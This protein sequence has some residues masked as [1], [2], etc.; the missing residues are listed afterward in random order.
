MT[1]E[2]REIDPW[3]SFSYDFT[4]STFRDNPFDLWRR[5]RKECPVAHG[6]E[7]ARGERFLVTSRYEDT[8]FAAQSP[9]LFTTTQGVTLPP[10]P[11]P[12]LPLELDGASHREMRKIMNPSLAPQRV[13]G[14]ES[15]LRA[16]ARITLDAL[17]G[18]TELDICGDFSDPYVKNSMLT[19]LGFPRV[20][21]P[22]LRYWTQLLSDHPSFHTADELAQI[23]GQCVPYLAQS[24]RAAR[25]RDAADDTLSIVAHGTIEGRELQ[26]GEQVSMMLLLILGALTTTSATLAG[27]LYWLADH[28]E[29]RVRLR[30]QPELLLTAVDEFVRYTTPVAHEAR[31]ATSTTVLGGCP[32]PAGTKVVL[33]YGSANRDAEVFDE[34]EDIVLDRHPNRHLGFGIGPHRCVGLHL[35]KL[36]LRVGIGEF[37]ER[38]P[39][40][41]VTDHA[42]VRHDSHG[43]GRELGYVPIR[44]LRADARAARP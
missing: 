23:P 40:F 32:V 44:V 12:L 2:Q 9:E 8:K 11:E 3:A 18:R 16:E 34:P 29:D 43:F 25:E 20:D 19:M 1:T 14:M 4:S 37:L 10:G 7:S 27:A 17:A 42:A 24:L 22:K 39:D 28:V 15:A 30:I 38:M 41:E 21:L 5:M 36:A 35:A 6:E 26:I 33:G 31:T 13:E